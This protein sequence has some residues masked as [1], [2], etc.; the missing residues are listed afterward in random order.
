MLELAR[1]VKRLTGSSSEIEFRPLPVDDPKQR[2]PDLTRARD[3]LG[4]APQVSPED[5]LRRTVEYFRA[6]I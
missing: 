2:R 4:W 6:S 3:I 1:L 5:G